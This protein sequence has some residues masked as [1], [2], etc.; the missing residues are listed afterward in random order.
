LFWVVK[1]YIIE[2]HHDENGKRHLSAELGPAVIGSNGTKEYYE[3]GIH[4]R[5]YE[6]GPARIWSDGSQIYWENGKLHRPHELGPAII[7]SNG[8]KEYWE[9]GIQKTLKEFKAI[10][11]IQQ[12]IRWQKV[13]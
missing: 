9:N 3:H 6:L 1:M 2:A 10:Y 12:W 8:D 13:L 7:R 11:K 5:S 4:H